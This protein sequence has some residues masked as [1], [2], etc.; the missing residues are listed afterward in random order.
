V[1]LIKPKQDLPKNYKWA[2]KVRE[3]L[4]KYCGLLY[5]TYGSYEKVSQKTA[6]DRRTVKKYVDEYQAKITG[7]LN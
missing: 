4:S 5:E 6:L 3:L 2:G 7:S 1:I